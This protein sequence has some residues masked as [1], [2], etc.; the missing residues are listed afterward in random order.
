M[1]KDAMGKATIYLYDQTISP[2]PHL[3]VCLAAL[4]IRQGDY[5]E[6]PE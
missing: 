5:R 3:S 2:L 1:E 4:K 6:Y